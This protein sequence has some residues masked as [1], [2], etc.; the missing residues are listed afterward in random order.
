MIYI[1]I[2]AAALIIFF[3]DSQQRIIKKLNKNWLDDLLLNNY[4]L[5]IGLFLPRIFTVPHPG[6]LDCKLSKSIV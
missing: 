3:T 1:L 5:F 4:K 2:I 6:T